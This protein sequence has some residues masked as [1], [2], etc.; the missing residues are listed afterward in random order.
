VR[1]DNLTNE[2]HDARDNLQVT[3]GR[4]VWVGAGVRFD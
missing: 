3:A 2:Q 1:V 4:T